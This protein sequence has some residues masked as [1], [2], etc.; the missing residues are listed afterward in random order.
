MTG[1]SSGNSST[2]TTSSSSTSGDGRRSLKIDPRRPG[3]DFVLGVSGRG[4]L[5][6]EELAILVALAV[7]STIDFDRS[8]DVLERN[9]G[10]FEPWLFE[11]V[12]EDGE[13]DKRDDLLDMVVD[14]EDGYVV[15]GGD[16]RLSLRHKPPNS[17]HPA[18]TTIFSPLRRAQ[19]PGV[20]GTNSASWADWFHAPSP[21]TLIVQRYMK[22]R[23]HTFPRRS[24]A[25]VR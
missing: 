3:F 22:V 2:F 7:G 20:E 25:T 23:A 4:G 13:G 19:R 8:R 14:G 5:S 16:C 21:V 1:V 17:S 18:T 6:D 24:S 12:G 10:S 9:L 11:V 15:L